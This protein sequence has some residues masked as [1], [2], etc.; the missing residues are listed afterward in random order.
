M[1]Y[2]TIR[3]DLFKIDTF[4]QRMFR[5]W[6]QSPLF[7][8]INPF[9][10]NVSE[11]KR[12]TLKIDSTASSGGKG[13]LTYFMS[14]PWSPLEAGLGRIRFLSYLHVIGSAF[15]LIIS[16]EG[17]GKLVQITGARQS[18]RRLGA[19]LC[20]ICFRLCIFSI[21][22]CRLYFSDQARVTLQ[23]TVFPI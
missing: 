3:Q 11:Q 21:S 15:I 22:I 19:R 9:S 8:S 4:K 2:L 13:K 10:K 16:V 23:L 18:G 5:R 17:E 20:C 7:F 1:I 12:L 6:S 14:I